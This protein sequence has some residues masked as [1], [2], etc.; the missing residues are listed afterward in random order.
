V[1]AFYDRAKARA[2]QVLGE[3]GEAGT[4]R[5][6]SRNGTAY[7]PTAGAATDYAV[8]F[9]VFGYDDREV[10]GSRIQ[11]TDK[12]VTMAQ[13][14]LAIRPDTTDKLLIGG[15]EHSIIRVQP[16]APG[17]TTL[18]WELQVRR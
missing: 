14:D 5:R 4:L 13:N 12:K 7:N 16:L 3:K 1:S 2:D 15:V 6:P 18:L 9:V 8:T 10:D 17:G 11:S